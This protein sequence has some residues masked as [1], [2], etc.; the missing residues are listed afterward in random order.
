MYEI[1]ETTLKMAYKP[2]DIVTDKNGNVGFIQETGINDFQPEPHQISYSVKWIVGEG[3]KTAWYSHSEL[4]KHCNLFVKIA[5]CSCNSFGN[6]NSK[7]ESLM[8]VGF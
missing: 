2:Y 3:E 7:V 8:S 1:S 6:N 4:K 5:Q